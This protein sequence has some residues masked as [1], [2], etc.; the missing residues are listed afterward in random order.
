VVEGEWIY[1]GDGSFIGYT[2]RD[3][4]G[5]PIRVVRAI[6]PRTPVTKDFLAAWR[7]RERERFRDSPPEVAR[8]SVEKE[9]ADSLPA[10]DRILVD[11]LGFVWLARWVDWNLRSTTPQLYEVFDPGGVWLGTVETEPDYFPL[12][13]GE[14]YILG[15]RWGEF[16]EAYVVLYSLVRDPPRNAG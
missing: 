10:F 4:A 8:R 7:E 6:V 1:E 3:L 11:P 5:Q 14:D 12:E 2:V 16:A 15:L 13:V 9:A